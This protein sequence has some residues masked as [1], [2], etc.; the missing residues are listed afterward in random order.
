MGD[1]HRFE[2]V[3]SFVQRNFPP[4]LSI[5]DVAGGQGNLSFILAQEGYKCT[6][7]DPR[8]TDLSKNER[9]MRSRKGIRFKRIRKEFTPEMAGNFDLIIGLHPDEATEAICQAAKTKPVVLIPCC[10]YWR[11]IESHGSPSMA[12]TIRRFFRN[13]KIE[14]WE[15][16][17]KMNGKNLVFV[18]RGEK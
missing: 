16:L 5:A 3:A 15:T 11:G 1:R 2:V 13:N 10:R 9:R 7:I 14:W 12:K 6:I 8:N 18:T 17:L 4:P